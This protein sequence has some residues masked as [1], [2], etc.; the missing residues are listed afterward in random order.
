M[1]IVFDVNGTLL[2]PQILEPCLRKIFGRKL[3]AREWFHHL[4]QYS[5]ALTLSGDYRPFDQIAA[6]VLEM[7][8]AAFKVELTPADI[9]RVRRCMKTLPPYPEVKAALRKFGGA[10]IRLAVLTNSDPHTLQQQLENGELA[11]YFEQVLSIDQLQR[12]KPHTETYQ[13]A[14]RSLN[15]SPQD[16]L[17][18]AAHPWDLLGAAGAGC[19]TAFIRRPGKALFPIASQPTYVANNLADLA[20]Q[21]IP[22]SKRSGFPSAPAVVGGATALTA[23]VVVFTRRRQQGSSARPVSSPHKM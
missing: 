23:A 13:F 9:E 20:T 4:L 3:T 1:V 2:N 17:M 6:A 21:L 7:D 22:P 10:N 15:I 11:G 18:V 12:Y 19:L 14:A 8:A 16:M 5:M